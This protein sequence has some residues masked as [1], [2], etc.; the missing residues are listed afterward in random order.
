[1]IYSKNED[2]EGEEAGK[3]TPRPGSLLD[4]EFFDQAIIKRRKP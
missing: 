4:L 1:M 3:R 2:S